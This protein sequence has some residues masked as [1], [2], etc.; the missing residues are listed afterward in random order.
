MVK[1]TFC[2]KT[3]T[4]RSGKCN[5]LEHHVFCFKKTLFWP[6]YWLVGHWILALIFGIDLAQPHKYMLPSVYRPTYPCHP[7]HQPSL[8]HTPS[9]IPPTHRQTLYMLHSPIS[10]LQEKATLKK[11]VCFTKATCF[12]LIKSLIKD[13]IW[14]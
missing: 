1:Q 9:S 3:K 11:T 2:W 10:W 8:L 14:E 12:Y 4:L 7:C 5:L 13:R 6:S